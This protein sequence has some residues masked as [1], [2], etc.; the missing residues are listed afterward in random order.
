MTNF[1]HI[2]LETHGVQ[3]DEAPQSVDPPVM[4]KDVSIVELHM[5]QECRDTKLWPIPGCITMSLP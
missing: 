1:Q 4:L 5:T 2:E 3:H